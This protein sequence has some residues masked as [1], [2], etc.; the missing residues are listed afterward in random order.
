M[1]DEQTHTYKCIH[2]DIARLYRC[3]ITVLIARTSTPSSIAITAGI[4]ITASPLES[5]SHLAS[6]LAMLPGSANVLHHICHGVR[7]RR[8]P[9]PPASAAPS[10]GAG[11]GTGVS[12]RAAPVSAL[13]SAPALAGARLLL[14][15]G[16]ASG[17]RRGRWT[18]RRG[19]TSTDMGARGVGTGVGTNV[20][21]F[22]SP[23]SPVSP[24]SAS[25]SV[26]ESSSAFSSSRSSSESESS[27]PPRNR[28]PPRSPPWRPPRNPSYM[29]TLLHK[30]NPASCN[31]VTSLSKRLISVVT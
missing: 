17:H 14:G 13:D 11:L 19:G 16:G 21:A 8:P 10:V 7:S 12:E 9:Q 1:I 5:S 6:P 23:V 2:V 26:S 4:V 3:I 20:G 30:R 22:F 28:S 18:H 15:T 24:A 31:A 29:R 25:G 27:C